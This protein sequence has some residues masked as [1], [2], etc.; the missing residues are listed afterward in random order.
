MF[1]VM[2]AVKE[3]FVDSDQDDAGFAANLSTELG[4]QVSPSSIL[5]AREAFKIP[6]RRTLDGLKEPTSPEEQIARLTQ[7]VAALEQHLAAIDSFLAGVKGD[8]YVTA[9]LAKGITPVNGG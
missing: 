7:R 4:F 9:L 2:T 5:T 1:L 8:D 3:R 6:S